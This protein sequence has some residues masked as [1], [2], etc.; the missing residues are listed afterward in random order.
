MV[1][2]PPLVAALRR[3]QV[4]AALRKHFEADVRCFSIQPA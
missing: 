2:H 3:F 4:F 1:H